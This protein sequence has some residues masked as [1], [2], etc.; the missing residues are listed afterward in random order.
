[1]VAQVRFAQVVSFWDFSPLTLAL[2]AAR[3]VS[4]RSL[5]GGLP[6]LT[7]VRGVTSPVSQFLLLRMLQ[8]DK[9]Q[10]AAPCNVINLFLTETRLLGGLRPKQ[11]LP[12][13]ALFALTTASPCGAQCAPFARLRETSTGGGRWAYSGKLGILAWGYK[14]AAACSPVAS[15]GLFFCQCLMSDL[16]LLQCEN[17]HGQVA[18]VT[19]LGAKC[20]SEPCAEPVAQTHGVARHGPTP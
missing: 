15:W 7:S 16:G 1:M 17:G 6:L 18:R 9:T 19:C 11:F 8:P 13:R 12:N 3:Y 4:P 10:R 2:E 20:S 14:A 5:Q